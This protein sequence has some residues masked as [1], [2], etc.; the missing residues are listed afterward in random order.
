VCE[1]TS[2]TLRV[3]LR[4]APGPGEV[5]IQSVSAQPDRDGS[6]AVRFRV[7]PGVDVSSPLTISRRTLLPQAGNWEPVRSVSPRD[8]LLDDPGLATGEQVYEY[9]LTGTSGCNE[10]FASVPHHSILLTGAGD[11][12]LQTVHLDWNP[13]TGWPGGVK[14]YEVWRKS[15]EEE[16]FSLYEK[17]GPDA[18]AWAA[19]NAREGFRQCYRVRAVEEGGGGAYAWSNEVCLTFEHPLFVPNVITPNGDGYNDTW[20]IGNLELYRQHRLRVVNRYGKTVLDTDA[21]RQDWRGEDLGPGLYYYVLTTARNGQTIRGW[22]HLL[23]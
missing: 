15:D 10:P 2:D 22:V 23:R 19:A 7:A 13:Y 9:R 1:G 18:P 8:S 6:L 3:W 5:F 16:T 12:A 20:V 17:S 14:T 21:Y 11:E 4:P